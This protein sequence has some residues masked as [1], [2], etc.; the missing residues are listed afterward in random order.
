MT[1]VNL[2]TLVGFKLA[3]T[4]SLQFVLTCKW[5]MS[6]PHCCLESYKAVVAYPGPEM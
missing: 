1:A 6:S 2:G 5:M 3:G 4:V